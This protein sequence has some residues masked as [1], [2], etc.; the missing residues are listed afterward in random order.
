M[1]EKKN[2][3]II[4]VLDFAADYISIEVYRY[5]YNIYTSVYFPESTD[6]KGDYL[7]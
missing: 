6:N 4:F 2:I 7:R 3:L 1:S 5:I